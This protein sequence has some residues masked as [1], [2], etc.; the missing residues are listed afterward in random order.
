[1]SIER[2]RVWQAEYWIGE[3]RDSTL[4]LACLRHGF[5]PVYAKG[6]DALPPDLTARFGQA[7]VRSVEP[8]EL[9]R[10][11]RVA[12]ERFMDEVDRI[13]PGLA[14]RLRAPVTELAGL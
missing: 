1:M 12:A 13:D 8:D 9:R 3:L 11:L 2:G 5:P 7:L 6:V 10:A 4:T 14:D